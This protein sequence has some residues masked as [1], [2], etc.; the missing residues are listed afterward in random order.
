LDIKAAPNDAAIAEYRPI[1]GSH[2]AG[3]PGTPMK[4]AFR[5]GAK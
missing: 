2:H 4:L 5:V 3:S 1:A